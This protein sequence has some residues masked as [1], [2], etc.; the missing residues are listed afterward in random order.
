M[1]YLAQPLPKKFTLADLRNARLDGR[2]VPMLTCYDYT[3]AKLM[4]DA[5][6]PILL[7]GDSAANVIL[8]HST[9][10]PVSLEFMTEITAAV[11]RGAPD[12]LLIADLP[13][14]SYG[15]SVER[16][17]ESS[18]KLMKNTGADLIKIETAE[19]HLPLVRQL[20]DAGVGV[21]AHLG[22]RPQSVGVLGGFRAQGRASDDAVEIVSLAVRMQQAG[23]VALLL[24][25]VP[26]EVAAAVVE[27]TNVPVI[28]CGG[29]PACHGHVVVTH[30]ILG[31]TPR[32]P[33]F[34]PLLGDVATPIA[35]ALT[36][37][38][39]QVRDGVYPADEHNY[40]MPADERRKFLR[41]ERPSEVNESGPW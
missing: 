41:S 25:A 15:G 17:F 7:V 2:R 8:G 33:K 19:G 34:A 35:E 28:G 20:A 40:S 29:G 18:I 22:L 5:G 23:A 9:T 21:M 30:D 11:R 26:V 16:G 31:L 13:F 37:Y 4:H 32:R 39:Q 3:T 14:G 1:S 38:V 24:E 27:E 36:I 12:C 6:V 10:I